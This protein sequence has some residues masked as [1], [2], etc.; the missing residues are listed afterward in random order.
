M[1]TIFQ[2]MM[3]EVLRCVA[4]R[5]VQLMAEGY[6]AHD[7]A[8]AAFATYREPLASVMDELERTPDPTP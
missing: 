1:V 6:T 2:E 3:D 5:A 4:R 8:V 7:A